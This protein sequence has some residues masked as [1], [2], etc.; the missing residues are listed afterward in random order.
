MLKNNP[1]DTELT[2]QITFG[3]Q[4]FTF[5]AYQTIS[6]NPKSPLYSGFNVAVWKG[7]VK[8]SEVKEEKIQDDI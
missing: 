7:T 6:K 5:K 4:K 3:G 2:I 1:G 8:E